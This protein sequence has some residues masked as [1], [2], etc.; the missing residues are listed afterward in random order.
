MGSSNEGSAQEPSQPPKMRTVT[1]DQRIHGPANY[2]RQT[3]QYQDPKTLST[4]NE[5]SI[6][7]GQYIKVSQAGKD[8]GREKKVEGIIARD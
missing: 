3:Q 2:I 5:R 6:V 1:L 7:T 4:A 8:Q